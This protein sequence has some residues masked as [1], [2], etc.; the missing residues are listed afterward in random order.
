MLFFLDFLFP[1][2]RVSSLEVDV[3]YLFQANTAENLSCMLSLT[4]AKILW[5]MVLCDVVIFLASERNF[6][7]V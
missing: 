1:V 7:C 5:R 3:T 2:L 4:I 6:L